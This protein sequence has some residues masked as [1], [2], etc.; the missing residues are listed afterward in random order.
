MRNRARFY[1]SF[2]GAFHFLHSSTIV[3]VADLTHLYLSVVKATSHIRSKI[4]SFVFLAYHYSC[5]MNSMEEE[6]VRFFSRFR[7][8]TSILREKLMSHHKTRFEKTCGSRT[9]GLPK[10]L[11][12]VEVCYIPIKDT[13]ELLLAKDQQV[14]KAFLSHTLFGRTSRHAVVPSPFRS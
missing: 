14:V 3:S 1:L 5:P 10:V 12:T 13:L 6:I 8:T 2:T 11:H 4:F 7:E 9:R